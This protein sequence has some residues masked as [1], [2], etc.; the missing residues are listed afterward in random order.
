M[1]ICSSLE[2][3]HHV[4]A[5]PVEFRR[6]GVTYRPSPIRVGAFAAFG[7]LGIIPIVADGVAVVGRA[8]GWLVLGMAPLGIGPSLR[9]WVRVT[10]GAVEVGQVRGTKRF[11]A[12]EASV[13]WFAVPAGVVRDGSAVR[14]EGI[15][16]SSVTISLA[17]FRSGDLVDM[18]RRLREALRA[19]T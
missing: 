9:T 19:T 3:D 14:I 5:F 10:G 16:G 7:L 12:G 18:V 11:I 8:A 6:D 15:D 4:K 2:G 1:R 17:F 13:R